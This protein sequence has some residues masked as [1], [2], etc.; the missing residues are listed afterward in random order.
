VHAASEMRIIEVQASAAAAAAA[1]GNAYFP[2]RQF[3][4][5]VSLFA[6]H[7]FYLGFQVQNGTGSKFF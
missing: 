1:A 5:P 7:N 6:L 4:G 3:N 2:S